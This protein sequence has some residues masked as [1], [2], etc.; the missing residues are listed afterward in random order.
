MPRL[1]SDFFWPGRGSHPL[2]YKTTIQS[3]VG[4]EGDRT[5]QGDIHAGKAKK[6]RVYQAESRQMFLTEGRACLRV[7]T[8]ALHRTYPF[9]SHPHRGA[10]APYTLGMPFPP[11]LSISLCLLLLNSLSHNKK[12]LALC[13]RQ[14]R[15]PPDRALRD[16]V[17]WG[18]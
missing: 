9:L 7:L 5:G 13:L 8:A 6:R 18:C 4:H 1:S 17:A 14:N 16:H 3:L 10:C 11:Q 15:L 2:G 12:P